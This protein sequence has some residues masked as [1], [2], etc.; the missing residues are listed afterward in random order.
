LSLSAGP[1][2]RQGASTR[3][4]FLHAPG[5][6]TLVWITVV[7]GVMAITLGLAL[8]LHHNRAPAAL[9][10]F[11]GVYWILNGMVT[12]QVGMAVEGTRRRVALV[13][14]VIGVVTG[15]VVL[16]VNV[17]TTFLLSILGVVIALTGIVH[18]RGGFEL[19]DVSGRRWR[20][21]VPL[22]ILEV[23]LGTTLVLTSGAGGSLST[24]LASAWAILGGVVLVSDA[25]FI[26]RR[27][28]R[29]ETISPE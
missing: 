3:R 5:P 6:M 18:L 16:L 17:E 9:A 7:R 4:R 13:A 22:G 2:R 21:G 28:T 25:L 19:A 20:P 24:W 14:G 27:L 23:G 15:A 11:M 29:V 1:T 26:R 12:F 8:A 10:N